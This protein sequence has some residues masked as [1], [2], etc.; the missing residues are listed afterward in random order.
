MFQAKEP[1]PVINSFVPANSPSN[2]IEPVPVLINAS[3]KFTRRVVIPPVPV[4]RLTDPAVDNKQAHYGAYC[5]N[6]PV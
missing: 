2:E 6:E 5:R 3:F 1:V 4:R